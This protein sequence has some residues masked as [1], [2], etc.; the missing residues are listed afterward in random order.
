MRAPVRATRTRVNASFTVVIPAN[1]TSPTSRGAQPCRCAP[2][3]NE[4]NL[5][6]AATN[7][8]WPRTEIGIRRHLKE[9]S[10]QTINKVG[11]YCH[12]AGPLRLSRFGT[13]QINRD[14]GGL[15]WR[16]PLSCTRP[17]VST[18]IRCACCAINLWC[19]RAKA[20]ICVCTARR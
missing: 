20:T 10:G 13:N 8:N 12:V 2:V 6:I 19:G 3:A 9:L 4:T 5:T 1:D 15:P 16:R 14:Q 17:N 7:V 11:Y 18:A